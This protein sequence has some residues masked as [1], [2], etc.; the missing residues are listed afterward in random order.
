MKVLEN[1]YNREQFEESLLR[2]DIVEYYLSKTPEELEA[3]FGPEVARLVGFEQKNS[4]HC[5]D[6]W[7]HT[8]RTVEGIKQAQLTHEKF[9]K[10]RIA[11]FFHDIG[12]PDV[13]KFN[14]RTGQQVFYGHAMHSVD[15]ATPILEKLGYSPEEI[16]QLG[17][18]I[19]HHDDFI[20]YKSIIAPWMKTHE[21][22]R[23]IDS[24]TVS[25]KIIEN[26][27]D[28]EAM[29][30]DKD[31]I[32]YICYALGHSGQEPVFTNK[33]G[34]I[35]IK[36]DMAEVQEKIDSGKYDSKYIASEEDYIMLLEL[37]KADAGAQ[38]EIAMQQGRE[39]GSK[40]EKLEIMNSI[41]ATIPE[42]YK[43]VIEKVAYQPKNEANE[44]MVREASDENEFLERMIQ[45]A[46]TRS[47]L[48]D[49]NDRAKQ[50]YE[51]YE[52][53]LPKDQQSLDD[54]N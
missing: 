35:D 43:S 25:E 31:Q 33:D 11:A 50:L 32:R 2:E 42:A 30:Y 12:K 13:A 36:V 21:F 17:F 28:F 48:R 46:T 23:G 5:Y 16:Q 34:T 9:K 39:V 19:G 18:Y 41:Q 24:D 26:Q 1:K 6:L 27:Y 15:V 3:E 29:G 51:D 49:T 4:H 7:E 45:Y 44:K 8:L 47:E 20:S 10:L 54:D 52:S 38:S 14:E 53:Q 40:K 22:L 37:C